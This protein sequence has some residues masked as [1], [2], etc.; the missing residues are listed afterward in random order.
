LS[1]DIEKY[2]IQKEAYESTLKV[3][4]E[5]LQNME[6]QLKQEIHKGEELKQL[7]DMEEK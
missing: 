2:N 6:K 4:T 7:K 3:Y 1:V 5:K